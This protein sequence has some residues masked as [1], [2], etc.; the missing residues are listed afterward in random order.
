M[1]FRAFIYARIEFIAQRIQGD[2]SNA[3]SDKRRLRSQRSLSRD[4]ST[5]LQTKL[6]CALH[7]WPIAGAQLLSF[8][9]VESLQNA[10]KVLRTK[11][12]SD[13]GQAL[14]ELLVGG[15]AE[16]ERMTQG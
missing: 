4:W 13:S 5:R 3:R 10:M 9:R 6:D 15:R 11:S 16:K 12:F 2:D 14:P 8:R 1:P 7:S